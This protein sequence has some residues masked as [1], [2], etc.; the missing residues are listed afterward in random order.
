MKGRAIFLVRSLV[1]H[2]SQSS[3]PV[4]I[5]R[6]L[7]QGG[8]FREKLKADNWGTSED[9]SN[10][11]QTW[12]WWFTTQIHYL[13]KETYDYLI[14][15]ITFPK[16]AVRELRHIFHKCFLKCREKHYYLLHNLN[17]L[18]TMGILFYYMMLVEG[19]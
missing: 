19:S 1:Q 8:T 15:I 17:P 4:G 9:K 18:T 7:I 13:I 11:N 5:E 14:K 16:K 12:V 2:N 6:G 3:D 10:H